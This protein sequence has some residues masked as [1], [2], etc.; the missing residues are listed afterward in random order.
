MRRAA[1]TN[2][3]RYSVRVSIALHL[4]YASST[5]PA[6][7]S[8]EVWQALGRLHFWLYM[9]QS[10]LDKRI[11]TPRFSTENTCIM[12]RLRAL[13]PAGGVSSCWEMIAAESVA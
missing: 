7:H 13:C 8:T 6:M 1:F 11:F 2:A 5:I 4:V 3:M 9:S 12:L 10:A